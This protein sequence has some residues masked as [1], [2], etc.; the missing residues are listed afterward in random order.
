MTNSKDQLQFDA[1]IMLTWSDWD[2]EP[3]SNRYHYGSRFEKLVPVYFL[4]H[5]YRDIENIKVRPSGLD[6]LKIVD[7]PVNG[8]EKTVEQ[9]LLTLKKD[10][11][12][13]PIF[14]IYDTLNYSLLLSKLPRAFRVYHATEDY[15]TESNGWN[16]GMGLVGHSVVNALGTV[17]FVVSCSHGVTDVLK[18]RGHFRGN[19][20][21][22]ENGC[23]ADYYIYQK[24]TFDEGNNKV[25][26]KTVIFQGGINQ[27]IDYG[28]LYEVITKMPDWHFVFCGREVSY[29]VWDNIKALGNVT[30]YDQLETSEL[31]QKMCESSVGIIPYIQDT[32][33][34]NSYPLKALEYMACGLPVVSVPID[35]LE[36]LRGDFQFY[37]D[38]NGLITAIKVAAKKR[39][40]QNLIDQRVELAK[41]NSYDKRFETMLVDLKRSI[42]E[43]ISPPRGMNVAILYDSFLSMHVNCINDHLQSFRRFSEHKITYISCVSQYWNGDFD[44]S[45]INFDVFDAIVIHYSVRIS[46]SGHFDERIISK[47]KNCSGKKLIFIQDE[48]EGIQNARDVLLRLSPDV[49]YTCVPEAQVHAVYPKNLFPT[50]QFIQTLTGFVPNHKKLANF[51]KPLGDRNLDICYRGRELPE[52][53]GRLGNEKLIIGEQMEKFAKAYGLRTDISSKAEDRLYGDDWYHFLGSARV[54]IGSESGASIFDFDGTIQKKIDKFK[55]KHPEADFARIYDEILFQYDGKVTMNQ[56]SPKIYEAVICKTALVLFEGEYSG[57]IKPH[58]HFIPLKKDFSNIEDVVKKIK[59]DQYIQALTDR[60]FD[61]IILSGKYSY[62]TLINDF[63]DCLERLC[64]RRNSPTDLYRPV[65]VMTKN[66]SYEEAV[67]VIS[68]DLTKFNMPGGPFS[69]YEHSVVP[70]NAAWNKQFQELRESMGKAGES[71]ASQQNG[72]SPHFKKLG[73]ITSQQAKKHSLDFVVFLKVCLRKLLGPKY[74]EALKSLI[75]KK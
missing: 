58:D 30:W 75:G 59:D 63:D 62:E 32:W 21:T 50:T 41:S 25:A 4:Q 68:G 51:A 39:L 35:A 18:K 1:V 69:F 29:L 27:R 61:D 53:Y 74:T 57:V 66:G 13:N 37:T 14:W 22:V 36:K 38:A 71:S 40:D 33:I 46:V 60:A 24:A 31:A 54:T 55:K 48:Y 10:G 3:R 47:L 49:I 26:D 6:K 2:N 64:L 9:F 45:S 67:P 11:I 19:I 8:S 52:I 70:I 72:P 12:K 7:M 20:I 23:D 65:I 15:I 28:I 34:K 17:D 43:G 44:P 56:I 16:Q 73:N 42:R 5:R